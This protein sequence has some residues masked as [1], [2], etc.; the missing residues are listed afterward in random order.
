MNAQCYSTFKAFFF[1]VTVNLG[2]IE[3]DLLMMLLCLWQ[4][5]PFLKITVVRWV[6]AEVKLLEIY[7]LEK[8]GKKCVHS[9]FAGKQKPIPKRHIFNER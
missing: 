4:T 9:N 1:I 2:A 5:L 8:A 3:S 6:S 7:V